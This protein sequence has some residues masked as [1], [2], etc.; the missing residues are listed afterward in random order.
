MKKA[1]LMLVAAVLIA[2]PVTAFAGVPEWHI[3]KTVTVEEGSE[4]DFDDAPEIV[5]DKSRYES[6]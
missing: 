1:I 3:D 5:I 2:M 4:L 6:V